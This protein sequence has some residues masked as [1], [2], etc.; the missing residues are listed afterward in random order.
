MA[1]GD[2]KPR[3]GAST[4]FT[5]TLASLANAAARQSS[6]IDNSTNKY[7][8][9]LITVK[10]MSGVSTPTAGTAYEVYLLRRDDH[11][12]P[13]VADDN[14]GSSD[15]AITIENAALL[16]IIRVTANSAKA[17]YGTFDTAPLGVLGPSWGIAIRNGSGQTISSTE[18]DHIERYVPYYR[19][20]E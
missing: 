7:E 14:A 6:M 15:A 16:G 10:I 19:A 2:I 5:I 9:A 1:T 11:A 12:S 18:G 3:Y 4:A 20:V 17:F 13:N 8:G